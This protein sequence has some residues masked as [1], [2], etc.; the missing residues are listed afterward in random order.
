MMEELAVPILLTTVID[1]PERHPAIDNTH[2]QL[3]DQLSSTEKLCRTIAAWTGAPLS[4]MAA[5][6]LQ[7]IWIVLGI[8]THLDP[9]PFVFLLTCSNVIQL[10]LIFVIAVAQRQSSMH[11]ELRA[12]AD[13]SAISRL[14]YH[15]QAQELILLQL[16]E[17]QGID[18]IDLRAMVKTLV[19]S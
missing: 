8:V 7:L 17:K 1:D 12:E 4:L 16:A 2:K 14:L 10:I 9:F 18:T 11:D 5:I 19:A 3:T 15:Q 6:V 13:H